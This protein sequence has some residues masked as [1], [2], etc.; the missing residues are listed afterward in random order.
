MLLGTFAMQPDESL[1]YD[2]DYTDW[3][4]TG[5]NVSSATVAVTPADELAATLVQINDPRVKV[6]L[7]GGTDGTTYKVS[8]TMT[9]ADGRVKQ[10]EFKIR[11]KEI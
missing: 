7:E 2:L 3:L 11:V 5:D 6:W 4:T 10:D 8:V 9:T 1:D